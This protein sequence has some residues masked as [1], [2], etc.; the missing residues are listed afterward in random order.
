[1]I[2]FLQCVTLAFTIAETEMALLL[3]APFQGMF[4]VLDISNCIWL[5]L[6]IQLVSPDAH[7]LWGFVVCLFLNRKFY[8]LV[9]TFMS[10]SVTK[11]IE[12][13]YS[14]K[15][16]GFLFAFFFLS[17]IH[18]FSCSFFKFVSF[19]KLGKGPQ[20]HHTTPLQITP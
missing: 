6:G 20:I 19:Q 7:F 8:K 13:Q 17:K 2:N 10:F 18:T 1:M 4:N 16:V 9:A 15:F 11:N 12:C 3:K 5:N 14:G